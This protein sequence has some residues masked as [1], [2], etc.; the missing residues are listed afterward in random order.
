MYVCFTHTHTQPLEWKFQSD[1]SSTVEGPNY[2]L[3]LLFVF[4]SINTMAYRG[5][6]N[7]PTE[8]SDFGQ[9]IGRTQTHFASI[10]VLIINPMAV[11]LKVI[12]QKREREKMCFVKYPMMVYS[13]FQPMVVILMD[14]FI[15][16]KNKLLNIN[17][18]IECSRSQSVY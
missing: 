8:W 16:T 11:V 4:G 17:I 9:S 18:F 6:K 15:L 5:R 2:L 12:A 13:G 7:F 10:E 3:L 14:S 1:C